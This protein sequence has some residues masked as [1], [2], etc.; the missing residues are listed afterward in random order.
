MTSLRC[1]ISSI[2]MAILLS[3]TASLPSNA[4]PR[5]RGA[6]GFDGLWS[7]MVETT[8]GSCPAAVRAGARILGSQVLAEDPSYRIDGRVARD[9]AVRVTVFAAGQSGGAYGRLSGE[10]GRGL[11][12]TSSGDCSGTWTAERR[13][14]V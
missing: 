11:W 5:S 14:Q 4:A 10:A 2:S 8:R 3:A 9:G 7:L 1:I 12:R 6:G 13:G